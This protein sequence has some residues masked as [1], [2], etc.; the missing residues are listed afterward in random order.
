MIKL[1]LKNNRMV[2]VQ[3]FVQYKIYQDYFDMFV[4]SIINIINLHKLHV[5]SLMI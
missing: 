2:R 4:D 1:N 3:L 5:A